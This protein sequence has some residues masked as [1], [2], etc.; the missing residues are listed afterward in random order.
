VGQ[1]VNQ[2]G[3]HKAAETASAAGGKRVVAVSPYPL[4][5]EALEF[6]LANVGIEVVGKS[7][8]V[9]E[10]L[11][12]VARSRPDVLIMDLDIQNESGGAT[13]CLQ[14][15]RA[16]VPHVRGIVVSDY[17]DPKRIDA[18]FEA[19]AAAYVVKTA[20]AEDFAF[21][22]RQAFEHAVYIALRPGSTIQVSEPRGGSNLT[23]REQEILQLVADGRSNADVARLLW[24]TE[25]TVKFH[26]ANVY[27]KLRVKNRT[28]AARWAHENGLLPDRPADTPT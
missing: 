24:V 7:V 21:A 3:T 23:A 13:A 16:L 6:S 8:S 12:M 20:H 5:L 10:A 15:A 18:A 1:P 27:R 25:Q 14:R 26:L 19:G 4:W 17:N 9:E 2:G 22:V 28:Q 11:A